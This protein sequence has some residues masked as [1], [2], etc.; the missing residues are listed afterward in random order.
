MQIKEIFKDAGKSYDKYF[1]YHLDRDGYSYDIT[2]YRKELKYKNNKP[3][4]L[5]YA[6]N[7][8]HMFSRKFD[9]N[10]DNKIIQK[11]VNYDL[12]EYYESY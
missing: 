10:I 5:E 11:I 1:S 7:N 3:T 12:G 8:G 9:E 4:K 2:S 6:R